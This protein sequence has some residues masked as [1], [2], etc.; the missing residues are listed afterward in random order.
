LFDIDQKLGLHGESYSDRKL[1][2]LLNC[3]VFYLFI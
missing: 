2:Y 3:Q 1:Q